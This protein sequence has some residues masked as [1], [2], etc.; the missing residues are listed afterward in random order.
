M[1]GL[2]LF[3]SLAVGQDHDRNA[4][5]LY[6][7]ITG[8]PLQLSDPR[9]QIISQ[10]ITEGKWLEAAHLITDDPKF[11]DVTVRDFAAVMS[12]LE[13]AP[14]VP[15]NDFIADIVGVT[16]D[17]RDARELLNGD[18]RYEGA[19]SL[20]LPPV[21]RK[22]ND[23]YQQLEATVPSLK[24]A[25]VRRSPQWDDVDEPGGLLTTRAWGSAHF[26]G[27]TNRRAL[28]YAVQEL[29]CRPIAT[30]KD[31]NIPDDRVRCDVPRAP[32]KDPLE[33]QNN[34]RGC[35]GPMDAMAGAFSH[36][37]FVKGELI[38]TGKSRVV[39]KVVQNF[40][41]F[42]YGYITRDSSWI[43]YLAGNESFGWRGNNAGEGPASLGKLLADSDAFANCM[44]Q[45]VFTAVCNSSL[46]PVKDAE[47][48]ELHAKE[49]KAS[50]YNLR[51]LFA[52]TAVSQRCFP[53]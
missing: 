17:N 24:D 53:H 42:P 52:Y 19:Q 16:R 39:N 13:L 4:G 2:S 15:L 51:A 45:R 32:G 43:N 8:V 29:L 44:P 11:Y 49:F 28:Q 35:H 10:M 21:S 27:G 36:F 7:N 18:F 47:I 37:D 20:G 12:N 3:A 41:V 14:Y 48:I 30:W 6:Q 33:Y 34:C 25:L 5:L 1:V 38:Y 23:H 26:S 40:R 9:R 50:G 31:V 46:D 22:N